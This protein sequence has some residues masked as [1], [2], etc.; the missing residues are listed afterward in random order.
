MKNFLE[1]E[2]EKIASEVLRFLENGSTHCKGSVIFTT[3]G[4]GWAI[5]RM[6]NIS[7]S[8]PTNLDGF[9]IVY[10]YGSPAWYVGSMSSPPVDFPA[11]AK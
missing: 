7:E 2:S 1:L 5:A 9:A 11:M 3:P 10:I 8:A 4:V 6:R